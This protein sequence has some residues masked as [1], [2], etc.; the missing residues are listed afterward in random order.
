MT[1]DV[2]EIEALIKAALPTAKVA[3]SG[4][5]THFAASVEAT[6]FEGLN[7]VQQHKLVYSAVQKKIEGSSGVL[8]ALALTTKVLRK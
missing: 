5:G 6:E 3:V 8:H 2:L 4:D 7:R 1:I